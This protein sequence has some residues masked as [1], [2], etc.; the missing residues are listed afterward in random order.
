M[1]AES[2]LH[3]DSVFGSRRGLAAV[4]DEWPGFEDSHQI[5]R[6]VELQRNSALL[7]KS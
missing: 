1:R 4:V 6:E 3:G 7:K 5:M 2:E